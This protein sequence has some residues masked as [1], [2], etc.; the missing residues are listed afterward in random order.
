MRNW[1]VALSGLGWLDLG[2]NGEGELVFRWSVKP[3]FAHQNGESRLGA[4]EL[5][6]IQPDFEI[7]VP[8]EV[9]F[10]VRWELE[11]Y[12]ENVAMDVM[13]IYR[14]SRASIAAATR[15]NFV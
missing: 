14:L 2:E 12:C 15:N 1:L 6:Y 11:L 4:E 9:S 13:S 3:V 7:I 10:R 5:F 8:P